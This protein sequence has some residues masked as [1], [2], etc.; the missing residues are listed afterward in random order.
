MV[1]DT[2]PYR[3]SKRRQRQ[4]SSLA[5]SF[6]LQFIFFQAAK[7]MG[8]RIRHCISKLSTN[9]SPTHFEVCDGLRDI[10][11]NVASTAEI[12]SLLSMLQA[13]DEETLYSVAETIM[14]YATF[15]DIILEDSDEKISGRMMPIIRSGIYSS[16]DIVGTGG[17]LLFLHVRPILFFSGCTSFLKCTLMTLL[18]VRSICCCIAIYLV[19]F[20]PPL[21]RE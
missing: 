17:T 19:N 14:Q 10:L 5:R 1:G 20:V 11:D 2:L 12:K 7:E 6:L 13:Y 8:D 21:R 18:Y 16:L 15:P 4:C 3:L 9:A